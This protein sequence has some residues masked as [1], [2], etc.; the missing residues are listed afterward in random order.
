MDKVLVLVGPTAIGKSSVG[1][2]LAKKFN[3]EIISGDSVQI[4]RQ[5][6][7]GSAKTTK[8][9]QAG[10]IHH[11]IDQ[12]DFWQQYSV[13]DFQIAARECIKA[14]SD[15]G[16]LPIV[17]GGTGLYIKALLYDYVFSDETNHTD[18]YQDYSNEQ[19]W[20]AVNEV[21]PEAALKIH[22]NNR[23]RL[24]RALTMMEQ[25][26]QNKTSFEAKQSKAMVY[27]TLVI[28]LTINRQQLHQR[29][30][31]RVQQM[32][33][34]GLEIE[35]IDLYQQ[36]LNYDYTALQAIGYKEFKD[37][38]NKET[39][40][41]EVKLKIQSHTRQFAKRQFTWFNNQMDVKWFDVTED[42]YLTQINDL[43]NNWLKQ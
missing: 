25:L 8:Q 15:R 10:I 1:V 31:N 7:I 30:N 13:Y 19:L 26:S 27:D 40:L 24:V 17:V 38:F 16:N 2:S 29:I 35:V 37:Y 43:I 11:L 14:I 39:T 18:D 4:Y 33:D 34:A 42:D 28:G 21:D 9:Q 20:Q 32:F 36:S 22:P 6:N 3:G 5:L 41:E 12:L 23:R